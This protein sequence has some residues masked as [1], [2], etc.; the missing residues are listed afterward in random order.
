MA[1]PGQLVALVE[2]ITPP[3]Y[4]AAILIGGWVGL[5]RGEIVGLR[6]EDIDLD[7]GVV[8]V[9]TSRLEL[10]EAPVREDKAPKSRAGRR[11]VT[12]PPHVIPV[13]REHLDQ[14]AGRDRVFVGSDGEPLRGTPCT[15]PS[16]AHGSASASTG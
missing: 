10:L 3:K 2:A 8:H 4:R 6:R 1:T 14:Y 5:R 13:L 11:R 15:R 16:S 7:R 9:R 12:I